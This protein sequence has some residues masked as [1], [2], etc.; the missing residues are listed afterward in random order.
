MQLHS[1]KDR[2]QEENGIRRLVIING[3]VA[4]LSLYEKITPDLNEPLNM[5]LGLLVVGEAHS[6]S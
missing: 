6:V 3:Y 5:R 1:R 4:M 2:Q